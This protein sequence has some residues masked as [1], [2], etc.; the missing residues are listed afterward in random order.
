MNCPQGVWFWLV[1][2]KIRVSSLHVLR[3]QKRLPRGEQVQISVLTRVIGIARYPGHGTTGAF[4]VTRISVRPDADYVDMGWFQPRRH[5]RRMPF[6]R[7]SSAEVGRFIVLELGKHIVLAQAFNNEVDA[8]AWAKE[9]H[10]TPV[11]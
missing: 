7:S 10:E 3:E 2:V 5:G 8:R 11:P 4:G 9:R 1:L 6:P